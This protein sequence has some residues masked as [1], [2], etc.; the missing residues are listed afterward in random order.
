[1]TWCNSPGGRLDTVM[2]KEIALAGNTGAIE[3]TIFSS[4]KMVHAQL[5]LAPWVNER[6]EE[7]C[8]QIHSSLLF[9]KRDLKCSEVW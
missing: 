3:D 8:F 9:S 4:F 2:Q 1:M 7:L 5:Q 6:M